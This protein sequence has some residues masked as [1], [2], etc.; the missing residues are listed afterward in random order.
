MA[1][2]RK[3]KKT[4]PKPRSVSKPRKVSKPRAAAAAVGASGADDATPAAACPLALLDGSWLLQLRQPAPPASAPLPP[5][6]GVMRIEAK[7]GV[8]RV[9]GDVYVGAASPAA[10]DPLATPALHGTV[11]GTS[12]DPSFPPSEYRWYFRST[13]STYAAGVLSIS[14]VR[15]LW[16]G[17]ADDFTLKDTGS[18]R[19]EC[20]AGAFTLP[21]LP[22]P[23]TQMTGTAVIGGVELAATATKTSDAYRG[24]AVEVDLMLHRQ[25]PLTAANCAATLTHAFETIY[26]AAG[27]DF[28]PTID[29]RDVPEDPLLT[30]AELHALL[31]AQRLPVPHAHVWRL[32]MFV[33]SQDGTGTFGVMFDQVAPHREGVVGFFD[34][35][36]P[37][38]SRILPAARNQ[39]IG[40]VPLAFLRTL[41]HE[42]GHAFNLLH[43]KDDVHPT[44][45]TTTVMNQTGDLMVLAT[46]GNLFP[47]NA[48]MA[49]DPHQRASL[50]HSPDPQ[51]KPG[52]KAFAYGHGGGGVP[53]PVDAAG[54]HEPPAAPDL[55]LAADLPDRAHVGEVLIA[56]LTLTNLGTALARVPPRLSPSSGSLRLEVEGPTGDLVARDIVFACGPEGEVAL[57]PGASLQG[58]MQITYTNRGHVFRRPGTYRLHF[59][60][61]LPDGREARS[62]GRDLVV[63]LPASPAE[64]EVADAVLRHDVGVALALGDVVP[65]STAEA[66]VAALA[67]VP[68]A[69]RTARAMALVMANAAGRKFRDL[70]AE[71][72]QAAAAG[73]GVPADPS[74]ARVADPT[75]SKALFEAATADLDDLSTAVLAL[76]VASPVEKNAPVVL[77]A[78]E[79]VATAPLGAL[80]LDGTGV[81]AAARGLV[82]DFRR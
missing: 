57:A 45:V 47:C 62:A 78:E 74:L 33:G 40:K 39:A 11:I 23:T 8:L 26:R 49:F 25:W 68:T 1:P 20:R 70:A 42:A 59:V 41:T 53:E 79:R 72:V 82:R 19:L 36:L 10:A 29:R 69:S 32:W 30:M 73:P 35:V 21:T 22:R 15:H 77:L 71:P 63:R 67:A 4:R 52:W 60:L 61:A 37:D 7:N 16:Q 80:A 6:R 46:P 14:L 13:A 58:V 44:A 5:I 28:V 27:L 38:D 12:W 54:I 66:V 50:V 56:R 17:S 34:T 24:C 55:D 2:A 51:V 9:S 64:Q 65:G 31:A 43:P 76:S 18:L 75:T 81:G 48:T 3:K